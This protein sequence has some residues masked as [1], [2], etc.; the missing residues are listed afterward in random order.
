MGA[1]VARRLHHNGLYRDLFGGIYATRI[2][3][4][5]GVPIHENDELLP[6]AY[7]DY[8]DNMVSHRFI[9]RDEQ[10]LKYRLIFNRRHA[11]PITL[12]APTLFDFQA[13]GRYTITREEANEYHNMMEVAR[14][15]ATAQQ[16]VAAASQCNPNYNFGYPS[17]Q[18]WP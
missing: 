3:R 5:L 12:P 18:Y 11:V 15:R 2:A 10:S 16:A 6:P 1:I 13:K 14:L 17:G 7:L 9:E 4:R 8:N